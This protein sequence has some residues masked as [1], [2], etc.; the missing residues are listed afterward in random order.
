[1]TD[2]HLAGRLEEHRLLSDRCATLAAVDL[3]HATFGLVGQLKTFTLFEFLLLYTS[4]AQ[5]KKACLK[6]KSIGCSNHSTW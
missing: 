2:Y 1:M 4:E 6:I 3:L 5:Y